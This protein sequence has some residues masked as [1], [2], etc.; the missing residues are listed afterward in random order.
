[1]TLRQAGPVSRWRDDRWRGTRPALA[2]AILAGHGA[3]LLA[4]PWGSA[5]PPRGA[6]PAAPSAT[7]S[8]VM[9]TLPPLPARGA[10]IA[11]A[12]PLTSAATP[13]PQARALDRL[14]P[15]MRATT[16]PRPADPDAT[17]PIDADNPTPARP[18]PPGPTAAPMAV[19]PSAP[20]TAV[21]PATAASGP[22]ALDLTLPRG[23]ASASR[24]N[25][26][27]GLR[28]GAARPSSVEDHVARAT[29][30]G[31]E[32]VPERLDDDTVRLRNGHTCIILKRSRGEV[33]DP[34]HLSQRPLPWMAG[35]PGAC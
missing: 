32:W 14:R 28:Y 19:A 16:Q 4:V 29:A 2:L 34:F 15:P 10:A 21:P 27:L 17:G 24:V 35:P 23:S 25:P 13:A 8:P 31:G 11:V 7:Q 22:P 26:A 3:L 33:L 30:G 18:T 20:P 6:M 5:R 12:P 1:M 9:I